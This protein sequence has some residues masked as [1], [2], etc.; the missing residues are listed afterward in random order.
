LGGGLQSIFSSDKKLDPSN[1]AVS[2]HTLFVIVFS[3]YQLRLLCHVPTVSV[4][5]SIYKFF[6]GTGSEFAARITLQ[7]EA[8]SPID[9]I[10]PDLVSVAFSVPED[11][12]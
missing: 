7:L 1:H 12:R 5:A 11:R 4:L 8:V 2:Q 6:F 9:G 10:R 3:K